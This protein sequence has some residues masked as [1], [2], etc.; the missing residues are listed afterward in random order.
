MI[1]NGWLQHPDFIR[2]DGH[3]LK[4][5]AEPN[6]GEGG[7]SCHS[8]VGEEADFLD[9]VPN[10]FLDDSRNADGSFTDYAA[11]SCMF[12]LRKRMPHIQ[13]YPTWA[14]TWTSGSRGANTTTWAFEAEGGG[15]GNTSE[16]LTEHQ[17]QGFLAVATAWEQVKGRT[18][19]V[20]QGLTVRAHW[21]LA[22]DFGS[23]A[24]ACESGRYRHAWDR[25]IAG[26]R[27][28]EMT[29]EELARLERVERLLAGRGTVP[30]TVT[31]N[32]LVAVQLVRPGAKAGQTIELT[33][34]DTL[35]YLDYMGNNLWLGLA[36]TQNK[37]RALE[38][39]TPTTAPRV[40]KITGATIQ[41]D[42]Q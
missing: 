33:G 10:R 40:I 32:N 19:Q 14:S 8:V 36:G 11:A 17:V 25:L 28:G 12:I 35:A 41:G 15:I 27:Y 13:M 31:L 3:P 7:L 9:G 39:A 20:G 34:D 21:Q 42:V 29:P 1:V 37:V 5:Y 24:T 2:V 30:V 23:A 16:P 4:L 6:S 38:Q 18:L 26:E 22:K